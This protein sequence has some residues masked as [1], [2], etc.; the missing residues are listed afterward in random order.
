MANLKC[1]SRDEISRMRSEVDRL[2]DDLCTDF[3][4]PVMFCRIAGDLDFKKEGDTLIVRLELGNMNPDDVNV[5]VHKN[6]LIITAKTT[7][8]AGSHRK[9]HTFRKELKLPCLITTE[10][11]HAD[12][13]D[14][15]LE[16]RLPKQL[17]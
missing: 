12:F 3:G 2:F 10:E 7:D 4:L 17:A 15:M 1:W 11:V 13:N 5:S 14:G 16:V 9:L 8:I 6:R